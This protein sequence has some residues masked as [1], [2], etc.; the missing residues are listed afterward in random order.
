MTVDY[1]IVQF[2]PF[3]SNSVSS[4]INKGNISLIL[5]ILN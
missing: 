2:I 3:I 5:I 4:G 1:E